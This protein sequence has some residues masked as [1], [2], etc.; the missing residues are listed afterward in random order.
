MYATFSLGGMGGIPDILD[1][2]PLGM[3][4]WILKKILP[5]GVPCNPNQ[6]CLTKLGSILK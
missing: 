5:L 4:D 3:K 2:H 6:T 1:A